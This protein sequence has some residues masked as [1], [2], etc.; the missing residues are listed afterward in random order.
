[1]MFMSLFSCYWQNRLQS[2]GIDSNRD[3]TTEV[4]IE[5]REEERVV[6]QNSYPFLL[7]SQ[8]SFISQM[9]QHHSFAQFVWEIIEIQ[10]G[11]APYLIVV[12]FFIRSVLLHGLG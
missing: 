12:T 2:S 4:N 7:Y 10:S 6:I 8:A 5:V 11:C 3:H 9:I 1:M